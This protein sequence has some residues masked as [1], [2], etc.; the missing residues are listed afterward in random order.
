[1]GLLFILAFPEFLKV[2]MTYLESK[3]P[4]FHAVRVPAFRVLRVL[5]I[6]LKMEKHNVILLLEIKI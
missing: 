3:I 4:D 1:M 6:N 2:I 5:F